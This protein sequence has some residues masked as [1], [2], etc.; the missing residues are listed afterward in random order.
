MMHKQLAEFAVSIV[1]TN[2]NML[3]KIFFFKYCTLYCALSNGIMRTPL[4]I[5]LTIFTTKMFCF[6]VNQKTTKL[7]SW[8]LLTLILF[9]C[10]DFCYLWMNLFLTI[11]LLTMMIPIASRML[12]ITMPSPAIRIIYLFTVIF[13]IFLLYFGGGW[14]GIWFC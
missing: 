1:K 6:L 10:L 14:V 9:A 7:N 5:T 2:E 8:Q 12:R 11:F 13:C 3:L 4:N